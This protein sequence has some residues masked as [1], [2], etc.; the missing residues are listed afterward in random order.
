M[1]ATV[2]DCIDR[3]GEE[4]LRELADDPHADTLAWSG[5]EEA[6]GDAT[7]EID[8]YVGARHELPLE[9]APRVLRR[10]CVEIG[11]Y[12]R[13]DSADRRSEEMRKRYEDGIRLLKD[14]QSGKASLGIADPDPP[15]RAESPAVSV[16]A[17]PRV[18]T[19][20]SLQGVL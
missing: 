15:A 20:K 2:Q 17:A 13:A 10:L 19:R 18:M 14:I 6:L 9:P 16:D 3:R 4:N 12:R 11:I 5:L 1:Y 8:A 7:D